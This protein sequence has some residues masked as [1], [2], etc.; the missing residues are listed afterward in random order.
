MRMNTI[1][2]YLNWTAVYFESQRWPGQSKVKVDTLR[3][4]YR[5]IVT[6]GHSFDLDT[7]DQASVDLLTELL[8]IY[9]H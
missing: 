8:R 4:T 1:K 2:G 3:E 7:A 9:R 6:D 5:R